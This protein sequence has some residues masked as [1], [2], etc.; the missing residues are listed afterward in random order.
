M[1]PY[2]APLVGRAAEIADLWAQSPE[3]F[4]DFELWLRILTLIKQSI[5][6]DDGGELCSYLT[7][8]AG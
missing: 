2:M 6:V 7:R 4:E 8:D 3:D 5:E 1:T